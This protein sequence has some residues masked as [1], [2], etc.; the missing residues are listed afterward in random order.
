MNLHISTRL[1]PAFFAFCL[2]VTPPAQGATVAPGETVFLSGTTAADRPELAGLVLQDTQLGR[3]DLI[4]HEFY[5]SGYYVQNRVVRSD[6]SGNMIFAPRLRD[7]NNITGGNTQI[8]RVDISGFGDFTT[9]VN[10][11]TDGVG[12]RG[13]SWVTRSA[14]GDTLSFVFG[15]PLF[16]SNLTHETHED[17]F[18]FSI[19]TNA[20]SYK[21]TGT[22]TFYGRNSDYPDDTL[23]AWLDG[24]AVPALTPVPLPAPALLL[25]GGLA[26]LGYLR[27]KSKRG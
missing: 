25:L 3:F 2:T 9:D 11:R 5:A 1:L 18:F 14:D 6:I 26:G 24:I 12:E 16:T 10:Y 21:N 27:R 4:P 22:A 17:S 15:F 13:P 23:T 19:L 7:S 8:D 20:T